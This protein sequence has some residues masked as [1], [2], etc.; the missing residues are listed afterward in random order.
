MNHSLERWAN[1]KCHRSAKATAVNIGFIHTPSLCVPNAAAHGPLPTPSRSGLDKP[2]AG[3][4]HV[5]RFVRPAALGASRY[6]LARRS[7][8]LSFAPVHPAALRDEPSASSQRILHQRQ[9]ELG[10]KRQPLTTPLASALQ[11]TSS[12]TPAPHNQNLQILGV[13]GRDGLGPRCRT[14]L[15][16]YAP[17]AARRRPNP[18][19]GRIRPCCRLNDVHSTVAA[20]RSASVRSWSTVQYL[21][22]SRTIFTKLLLMVAAPDHL[23]SGGGR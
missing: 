23:R 1:F 22:C 13:P 18:L 9:R 5:P 20:Q 8:C 15:P 16:E 6:N 3:S 2:P 17:S 10:D 11:G 7:L 21:P 4:G 19:R 12:D 14:G